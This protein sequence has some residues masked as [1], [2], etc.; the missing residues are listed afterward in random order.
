MTSLATTLPRAFKSTMSRSNARLPSATGRP[1]A[2]SWRAPGTAQN[3]PNRM[4]A[5]S[6]RRCDLSANRVSR[7]SACTARSNLIVGC[8][9]F[10][11]RP[12][13]SLDTETSDRV[14]PLTAMGVDPDDV[15][16]L[17]Q[18]VRTG[19]TPTAVAHPSHR[20]VNLVVH[21]GRVD[22]D[23]A[24]QDLRRELEG[25]VGVAGEDRR[26]EAIHRAICRFD[27]L[28]GGVDHFHHHH[29]AEG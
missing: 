27:R 24:G 23:D 21:G 2:R 29:R 6:S 8:C 3:R 25:F 13:P 28:L 22:V 18:A 5:S 11:T 20:R 15:L 4:T 19:P 26:R 17:L 12:D 10:T 1:S 7:P 9:G 14:L 16:E